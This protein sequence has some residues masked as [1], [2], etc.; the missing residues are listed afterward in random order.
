[1]Y[2]I[3]TVTADAHEEINH[4]GRNLLLHRRLTCL[5]HSGV[6]QFHASFGHSA[7]VLLAVAAGR[8]LQAIDANK[9]LTQGQASVKPGFC[10]SRAAGRTYNETTQAASFLCRGT[11]KEAQRQFLL[12]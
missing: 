6:S 1:M 5:G 10:L 9:S 3:M 11:E 8:M 4:P 7:N 12:A 2:C